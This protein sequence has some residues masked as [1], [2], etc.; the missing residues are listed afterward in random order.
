MKKVYQTIV[1]RG[2]GNC[3]QAVVASLFNLELEEVPNYIEL[4]SRWFLTM[5]ETYNEKGYSLC[6]FNPKGD[7]EF[8]K[9]LLKIDGGVNGYWYASVESKFFGKEVTHAVVI[10]KNMNV[11]H[12][13]NPNNIDVI[14]YPEDI[15]EIDMCKDNWHITPEGK[16]ELIDEK[17]I[18]IENG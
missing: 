9:R 10:D 5:R 15:I 4:G 2:H 11:I 14:Y 12:D 18:E 7:I 6:P 1:D 17:V 3:M 8:T 13:P 16:I